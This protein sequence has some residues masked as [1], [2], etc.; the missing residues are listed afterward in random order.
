MFDFRQAC[1]TMIRQQL[2]TYGVLNDLVLQVIR[3]TP[4][5]NF[6]PER[7]Q[8]FS[9]AD[10]SIPLAHHQQMLLPEAEAAILQALAITPTDQVLEVGTGSGYFTALLAQLAAQVTSADIF[11]DF[12]DAVKIKSCFQKIRNIHWV[13]DDFSKGPIDSDETYD[14][15]VISG[16]LTALPKAYLNALKPGGRLVAIL[17][18]STV[19]EAVLFVREQES[20]TQQRLFETM[21]PY[22]INIPD[23]ETFK[24]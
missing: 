16:A 5:E 20:V 21:I 2:R 10:F 22:L 13:C 17:G 3:E 23:V 14:V 12:I 24:F 15:I 18:S 11:Q 9:Y 7:Y 6:V 4:R 19:M 1:D 8:S